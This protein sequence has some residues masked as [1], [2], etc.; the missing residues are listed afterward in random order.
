MAKTPQSVPA[1]TL[2]LLTGSAVQ[3]CVYEGFL[4]GSVS[5]MK[6]SV[7]LVVLLFFFCKKTI[8][9]LISLNVLECLPSARSPFFVP[10]SF[11]EIVAEKYFQSTRREWMNL[12]PGSHVHSLSSQSQPNVNDQEHKKSLIVSLRCPKSHIIILNMRYFECK[13]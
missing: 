7:F 9:S 13:E 2:R 11:V 12:G 6:F 1:F 10:P 5:W 4:K 8:Y 3:P